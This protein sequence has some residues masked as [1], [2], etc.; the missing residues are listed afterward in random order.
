MLGKDKSIKVFVYPDEKYGVVFNPTNGF[1]VR[2]ELEENEEPFMSKHGPELI[3]ISITNW[4]DKG[5]DFCYKKSNIR[6]NH[7][8]L[9]TFD[10]IL[11]QAQEMDTIQIAL[12][13]G[14]PNQHPNFC[15]MI[16]LAREK[17][18]IIPSYTT[19]GRGLSREV[20]E[21]TKKYCGSVAISY[22]PPYKDVER[23]IQLL[24]EHGIKPNMHFLIDSTSISHAV[25]F[26][27]T[28][29]SFVKGL[30]AI[31]FLNYKPVGRAVHKEL[32]ANKNGNISTFFD[33]VNYFQKKNSTKV[34][35]D[36]CS[37]SGI[38]KYMKIDERFIESCEAGRFSMY[39]DENGCVYPCSFM[40]DSF[41]GVKVESSN[42][43]DI[44]QNQKN[45]LEIRKLLMSKNN[46][47]CING[48]PVFP[49]IDF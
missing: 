26:L 24:N 10:M 31:V 11:K 28:P 32:Y 27:Q 13:G 49:Q 47:K 1:F 29:P 16:K 21:Y 25:E 2:K 43:I 17:Y 39:I 48:C 5:C 9:D 3:D 45:F 44:W 38:I 34:G 37:V 36:S 18:D 20:L 40:I 15:E 12:G 8:S 7:M 19:N 4:C 23:S 14:N 33:A 22:Y 35:F 46:K 30:N 6:G 42:L 41:E